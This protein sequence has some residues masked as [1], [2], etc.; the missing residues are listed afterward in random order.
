MKNKIKNKNTKPFDYKWFSL[1]L[2]TSLQKINILL[3][4]KKRELN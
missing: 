4:D 2:S 1:F 3:K